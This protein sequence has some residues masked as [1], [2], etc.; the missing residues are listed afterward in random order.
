MGTWRRQYLPLFRKDNRNSE[1]VLLFW[2][3]CHLTVLGT[4]AVQMWLKA[5]FLVEAGSGCIVHAGV[6]TLGDLPTPAS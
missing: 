5:F 2:F 4:I 6:L 1:D 3:Y